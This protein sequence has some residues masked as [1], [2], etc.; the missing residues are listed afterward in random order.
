[1]YV[2]GNEDEIKVKVETKKATHNCSL[3]SSSFLPF[4]V[5]LEN[6]PFFGMVRR[7]QRRSEVSTIDLLL[8]RNRSRCRHN[9]KIIITCT[10]KRKKE[11]FDN[12]VDINT[13]TNIL[14]IKIVLVCFC[15]RKF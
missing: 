8:N 13:S 2:Y 5:F 6:S 11:A 12:T 9:S 10:R 1:M 3:S 15:Y 7:H 4:F 14:V